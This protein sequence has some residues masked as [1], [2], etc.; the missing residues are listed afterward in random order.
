MTT[1][2]T[3]TPEAGAESLQDLCEQ[4]QERLMAT[5][6]W[7]AERL[8]SRAE[9]IAWDARDFDTLARL[10]MPLQET[11]RQRRQRCG[12]GVVA[13]DLVSEGEADHIDPVHVITHYPHGQL[14]VAGWGTIAPALKVRELAEA[15]GLFAET[16]LA[17]AYPMGAGKAV[18][19][20][21]TADVALPAAR[22]QSIDQ[23]VRELPAHSIV[24]SESELPQ[25]VLKGSPETYARTMD[26]WE[27]LHGPFLA[28]ADN[29][30]EPI[31]KMEGYRRTIAVD[32]A[33]ELAHQKL[34]AV[35]AEL[36]RGRREGTSR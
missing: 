27:R 28:A 15:N 14:L 19:I 36:E 3:I 20:V 24:L 23:L 10:Y 6:Y 18:V 7:G 30:P 1:T 16:F 31:M 34:S 9:R 25:G 13:L 21:P 2:Q 29:T 35:A 5:D 22:G 12:E 17:A 33:C 4:G 26:L 11:R 8:L 32:Y